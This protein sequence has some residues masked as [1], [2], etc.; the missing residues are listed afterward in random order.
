[1]NFCWNIKSFQ[2]FC[3]NKNI[4]FF[5]LIKYQSFLFLKQQPFGLTRDSSLSSNRST[6]S[7][8][9][10]ILLQF[11]LQQIWIINWIAS[12][13]PLF[14]FADVSNQP[15]IPLSLQKLF[16]C[17]FSLHKLVSI[18]SLLLANKTA[19]KKKK[20]KLLKK[21][22]KGEKKGKKYKRKEN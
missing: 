2:N 16:I 6:I 5:F 11:I 10:Q 3:S 20:C 7:F 12:S 21:R 1:M 8:S 19:L 13:I 9:M 14:C 18:R 15:S 4:F 17:V 22:I